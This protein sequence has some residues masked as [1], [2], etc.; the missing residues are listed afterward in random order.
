[1]LSELKKTMKTL[2]QNLPLLRKEF[3]VKLQPEKLNSTF[4]GPPS[5]KDE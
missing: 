3:K 4:V 2:E 5:E 1:M